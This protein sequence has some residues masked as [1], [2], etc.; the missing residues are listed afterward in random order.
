M[1]DLFRPTG[2]AF[3][4]ADPLTARLSA[5]LLEHAGLKFPRVYDTFEERGV[6]VMAQPR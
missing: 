5:A 1:A 3:P 2:G 6:Q 4:P